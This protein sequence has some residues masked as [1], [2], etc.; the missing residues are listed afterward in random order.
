M[1]NQVIIPKIIFTN[2]PEVATSF[3]NSETYESFL[4]NAKKVLIDNQLDYIFNKTG[5]DSMLFLTT[6]TSEILNFEFSILGTNAEQRGLRI[7]IDFFD[8][9][10]EFEKDIF[11]KG[12]TDLINVRTFYLAFGTGS[13]LSNWSNFHVV[14]LLYAESFQDYDQPKTIRLNL[15]STAGIHEISDDIFSKYSK[16]IK[17]I[18]MSTALTVSAAV[19]PYSTRKSEEAQAQFD[20]D[21]PKI[22]EKLE[23]AKYKV[24]DLL[25]SKRAYDNRISE[26]D[27]GIQ[28]YQEQYNKAFK[29]L[30]DRI[31]ADRLRGIPSGGAVTELGKEAQKYFDR[32]QTLQNFKSDQITLQTKLNSKIDEA[33][34][35]VR[36]IEMELESLSRP[37]TVYEETDQ[38]NFEEFVKLF[39]GYSGLDYVIKQVVLNFLKSV[40]VQQNNILFVYDDILSNF[41]AS[42]SAKFNQTTLKQDE[43]PDVTIGA[44]RPTLEYI[45]TV[46]EKIKKYIPAI[47]LTARTIPFDTQITPIYQQQAE[48]ANEYSKQITASLKIGRQDGETDDK[49]KE[50]LQETFNAFEEAFTAQYSDIFDD[51]CELYRETDLR[52][53]NLFIDFIEKK[54]PDLVSELNLVKNQP[55]ILFGK[56]S[57]VRSL[58]YGEVYK[59]TNPNFVNNLAKDYVE[60]SIKQK[61]KKENYS[62]YGS[63]KETLTPLQNILETLNVK[64]NEYISTTKNLIANSLVFRHNVENGNVLSITV[65]DYKAYNKYLGIPTDINLFVPDKATAIDSILTTEVTIAIGSTA[66]TPNDLSK[67]NDFIEYLKKSQKFK[68]SLIVQEVALLVSSEEKLGNNI[69]TTNSELK[70][71]F[72]LFIIDLFRKYRLGLSLD[73]TLDNSSRKAQDVLRGMLRSIEKDSFRVSIKTL[74]FFFVSNLAFLTEPCLLISKRLKLSGYNPK[75]QFDSVI[76]GGYV[77]VGLKHKITKDSATSEFVLQKINTLA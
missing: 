53:V 61:L 40:F 24:K 49:F 66:Q 18:N 58:L 4:G 52:I 39:R 41:D 13:N 65:D 5:S 8:P 6:D 29:E 27:R 22:S 20:A 69:F 3:A 76:T 19:Q 51:R 17:N 74:P 28:E 72:D 1:T 59:I 42:G 30:Q 46:E 71:Q 73:T 67:L 32:K 37:E 55:L 36:D 2:V 21:K 64:N 7:V 9:S 23:V 34:K 11:K 47:E 14:S 45:N 25:N 54:S 57:I 44:S 75:S 60:N 31:E 16:G 56:K 77:I 70:T 43:D 38:F 68:N 33:T 12:L 62:L 15:V 48:K 35:Q 10:E 50:K 63:K 26:A